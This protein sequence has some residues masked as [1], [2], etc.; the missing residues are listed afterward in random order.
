VTP[1]SAACW[2]CLILMETWKR[3][4]APSS[5]A[6]V[7]PGASAPRITANADGFQP[8]A[9]RKAIAGYDAKDRRCRLVKRHPY[10]KQELA[11]KT[12]TIA[13][14]DERPVTVKTKFWPVIA[15]ATRDRDHNNQEIFRRYYL[16]VRQHDTGAKIVGEDTIFTP[17]EDG[18]CIVYGWYESSW[19]GESG[20]QAGYR[21][22]IDE[23]VAKIREVGDYIG[24]DRDLIDRC[25]ADLPSLIEE[26]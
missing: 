16:R 10:M 22:S 12:H 14:T 23:V 17:H 24:A 9:I 25:I 13:L 20:S 26:N 11:D 5:A 1:L 4:M 6:A 8:V 19:Q 2:D 7:A 3:M 21:C 18:R 15:K